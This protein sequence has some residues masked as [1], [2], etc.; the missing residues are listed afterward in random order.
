[1]AVAVLL[2]GA[3]YRTPN[4]VVEAPTP[5]LAAQVG[6]CAE[7]QRHVQALTWL[8]RDVPTW[9]RPC[10]VRVFLSWGGSGGATTFDYA[11]MIDMRLRGQPGELCRNVLP[12][13]VTHCIFAACFRGPVPR[14]ADEGGAILSEDARV[15]G[16]QDALARQFLRRGQAYRLRTLFRLDEY[17]GDVVVLY[18]E[19]YS[20]SS[21]LVQ[22]GGRQR[23]LAFVAAGMRQG[24]DRA[25]WLCYG[26]PGVD[27]LE[28]AW[29]EYLRLR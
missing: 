26:Y 28:R 2:S 23:F 29:L 11:G 6:Q 3:A 24:W 15:Q 25:A 27:D 1:V 21:F 18:A 10:R 7:Y 20:V 9:P 13:E 14:W 16:E 4:F 19:G 12:H 22:V 17:P 8:G 5:A